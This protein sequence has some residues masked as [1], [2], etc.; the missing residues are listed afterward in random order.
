MLNLTV[1]ALEKWAEQG[2]GPQFYRR[3]YSPRSRAVY[4]IEDVENFVRERYG[5][6]AVATLVTGSVQLAAEN[7]K[8]SAELGDSG[9]IVV[10]TTSG[11][12]T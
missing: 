9:A 3:G 12:N 11:V 1:S 2:T 5:D 7:P 8:P 10:A 4:R 6:D